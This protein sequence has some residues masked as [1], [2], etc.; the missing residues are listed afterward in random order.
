MANAK[1]ATST[2][3][4]ATIPTQYL[5]ALEDINADAS[6][7]ARVA[8]DL[9][10]ALKRSPRGPVRDVFVVLRHAYQELIQT[11]RA[12]ASELDMATI[13]PSAALDGEF[14]G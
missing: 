2:A 10:P 4:A 11:H 6:D 1:P 9:L 5:R 14:P 7:L 12:I 13:E 3:S 8:R